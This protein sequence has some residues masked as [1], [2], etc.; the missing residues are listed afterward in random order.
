[1]ITTKLKGSKAM[2]F[3]GK[4]AVITGAASGIGKALA[5][6]LVARGAHIVMADITQEPLE[7]AAQELGQAAAWLVCDVSDHA[8]VEAL[9]AFVQEKLGGCD[10]AFANAGVIMSGRAVRATPAE[11]DWLLGINVRGTWSTASVFTTLMA[12]QPEGG[13]LVLTGSEHSLGMQHAGSGIYT[14]SKHA[15]L[16]L[17]D[18]MRAEAP[19]N[20]KVSVLCPGVVGTAL[21]D[22]PRPGR[23]PERRRD[24]I[25]AHVMARGM[26]ANEAASRTLAGVAAGEFFI[27]THPHSLKAAQAR[28]AELEQA[29]AR[30]AP[31]FEGAEKWDINVIS[32]DILAG[33]ENKA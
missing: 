21:N 25:S 6:E 15:V 5:Q 1:M 9:A 16:G 22:Q 28:L 3:A 11:I 13:H 24:P 17:A 20:I 8:A 4:R 18:V 27:V 10:L 2:D 26:T 19:A 31:W 7:A 33:Q 29:Y 14:A 12:A 23:L 32:A 30:Q